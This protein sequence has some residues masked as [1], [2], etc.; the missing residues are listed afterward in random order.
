MLVM[1]DSRHEPIIA[2]AYIPKDPRT[3]APKTCNH[4]PFI[5]LLHYY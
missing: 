2:L 4:S 1:T 3:L 5:L